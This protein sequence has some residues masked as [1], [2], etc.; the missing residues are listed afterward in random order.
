MTSN[1]TAC[2]SLA[3][4]CSGL[5]L[6]EVHVILTPK[7]TSFW[8][9]PGHPSKRYSPDMS[10]S[11]LVLWNTAHLLASFQLAM[12]DSNPRLVPYQRVEVDPILYRLLIGSLD[13]K[14][15]YRNKIW[16]HWI[17]FIDILADRQWL[18]WWLI[19]QIHSDLVAS[20]RSKWN[21]QVTANPLSVLP[22][23][24]TILLI[25]LKLLGTSFIRI[26][27]TF[28][29]KTTT[30]RLAATPPRQSSTVH[31]QKYLPQMKFVFCP[32]W[33][34]WVICWKKPTMRIWFC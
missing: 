31:L 21:G 33:R 5:N 26:A 1:V 29:L 12:S 17:S 20:N 10:G 7:L 19:I 11:A 18:T 27:I 24:R 32:S 28:L 2:T 30:S 23:R 16:Q 4:F 3:K 6:R 34:R 14:W 22:I 25:L 13:S 15:Q 9:P 8:R